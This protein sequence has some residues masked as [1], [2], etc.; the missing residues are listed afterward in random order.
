[1]AVFVLKQPFDVVVITTKPEKKSTK[2]V[3]AKNKET[4][5]VGVYGPIFALKAR[6]RPLIFNEL[7]LGYVRL[8]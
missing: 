5:K 1:L 8:V 3:C 4:G 7:Q 6:I 2:A